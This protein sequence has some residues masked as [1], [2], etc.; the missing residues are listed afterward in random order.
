MIFKV[1]TLDD[2]KLLCKIVD[3]N[4]YVV[5]SIEYKTYVS[6]RRE[7]DNLVEMGNEQAYY[8]VEVLE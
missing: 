1:T 8:E 4:E 2:V 5:G 7:D 3:I 6:L